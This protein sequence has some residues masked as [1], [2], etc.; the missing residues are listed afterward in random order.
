MQDPPGQK[1][2]SQTQSEPEYRGHNP[3]VNHHI[4]TKGLNKI[5]FTM[6]K[7]LN[8]KGGGPNEQ[9]ASAVKS[10]LEIELYSSQQLLGQ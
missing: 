8:M 1:H 7:T 9:V 6:T 4:S 2:S 5:T 3:S 10:C